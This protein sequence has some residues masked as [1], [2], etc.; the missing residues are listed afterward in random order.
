MKK[1]ILN[2]S[3]E[4]SMNV[5]TDTYIQ[6]SMKDADT[7]LFVKRIVGAFFMELIIIVT[8]VLSMF[9][10]S[11]IKIPMF[12]MTLVS[13]VIL[14]MFVANIVCVQRKRILN[15]YIYYRDFSLLMFVWMLQ[16]FYIV[17]GMQ[18]VF[19]NT[20]VVYLI[21]HLILLLFLVGTISKE[22]CELYEKLYQETRQKNV[23][24]NAYNWVVQLL[25]K[26]LKNV[27]IYL[28]G[29]IL[30][31]VLP[32]E[33]SRRILVIVLPIFVFIFMDLFIGMFFEEIQG[34]YMNKY[35]D[36]YFEMTDYSKGAWYGG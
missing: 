2:A 1:T 20:K 34:Y 27:W 6:Q 24:L 23:I 9:I 30:Y 32:Y 13:L 16:L 3:L 26:M 25:K 18:E 33:M 10:T 29:A 31:V 35:L 22:S 17:C 5:V 36:D 28:I 14:F 15:R 19:L 8:Y 21:D 12:I 4:E 7:S 11:T